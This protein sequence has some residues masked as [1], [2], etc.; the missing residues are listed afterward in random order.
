ML[1]VSALVEAE[2]ITE[3]AADGPHAATVARAD[4]LHYLSDDGSLVD[5]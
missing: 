4:E 5:P 2:V 3:R 1:G